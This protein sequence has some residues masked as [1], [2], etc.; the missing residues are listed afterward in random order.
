MSK[1]EILPGTPIAVIG[2]G[3]WYPGAQTLRELWEN[4][5]ARRRQFRRM[6]DHRLPL[7]DYHDPDPAVPDKTYGTRAAV[8]DGFQFDWMSRHVPKLTYETADIVHW[9]AL[10]VA[11]KALADAGFTRENVPNEKTGV[12]LGNSLTGEQTRA[13]TLR[14]RWPFVRRALR[15]AAEA[16]G[17]SSIVPELELTMEEYY[18]SVFA[19]TTEDSL[20]GGLSNTVAGRICNFLNFHGGGYTVDGACSSSLIAVA[21]AATA[22]ANRDMDLAL[23][24]GV[25]VSLDT[26]E[27]IGFAKTGA[28]TKND[29]TVYDRKASGFIPGEGCGFVILKRLEDAQRDGNYV[30]AV[31]RGWG[32]SSDG[33]GGLT[34]PSKE[35]Q[36]TAL[37]RA[38]A[39]AG[40]SPKENAFFEGHGTGT[41]VGD[42]TE[43]QGIALATGSDYDD[44]DLRV[45]GVTS[46]KSLVG[47]TKAASG[48]GGFIKAVMAVNRCV[49]PPTAGCK[50]PNPMFNDEAKYL[51]PVLQ[52]AVR[53]SRHVLRAGVS[54][55]GFG[56]INCHVALESGDAPAEQLTPVIDERALLVSNQDSEV[57]VW[58]AETLSELIEQ[59]EQTRKQ[60]DGISLAEVTDLAAKLGREATA[61]SVR[62]AFIAGTPDELLEQLDALLVLLRD[63]PPDVAGELVTNPQNTLWAGNAVQKNR[64]GFL[65]PG[66]GAQQVNM[67]RVLVERYAWARDMVTAADEALKAAGAEPVSPLIF[68]PLDRALND[69]QAK[70]WANVLSRTEVAQPAICLASMI[71]LQYLARLGIAP[72]VVGGHSLGELTAFYAVGAFDQN[73]LIRLAALRGCAMAAPVGEAGTMAS[74]MCAQDIAAELV[75]D[76]PEYVVVANINSPKQTVIS[77]SVAGVQAVVE[78]AKARDIQTVMLSVSNAFHSRFVA[79]AADILRRDAP[80]PENL[81]SLNNVLL[82]STNGQPVQPGSK[83]RDHFA[84]QILSQVDFIALTRA[85]AHTC[86]VMI[87]VGPGRALSGLV[88]DTLPSAICL[89]VSSKPGADRDLNT[90]LARLFVQGCNIHWDALYENRLIRPFVPVKE[91][92]FIENQC[93]RPF[94]VTQKFAP[95]PLSAGGVVEATLASSANVS[96]SILTE[97]LTRRGRFLAEV[98]RADLD[99]PPLALPR[100]TQTVQVVTPVADAVPVSEQSSAGSEPARRLPLTRLIELVAQRTGYPVESISP[101]ARLLDDLNLDSIKAGDLIATVAKEYGI[102]GKIEP[103]TLANAALE[104]IANAVTAQM[105]DVSITQT[106]QQPS[107]PSKPSVE[108]VLLA[109]VE[110]RTGFPRQSLDLRMRLLDDL[111]LDSIKAGDL[112]ART[113]KELGVSGQIEPAK[114][115]NASLEDIAD[116]LRLFTGAETAAPVPAIPDEDRSQTWVRDFV[117]EWVAEAI[118]ATAVDWQ[119]ASILVLHDADEARIARLLRGGLLSQGVANVQTMPVIEARDKNLIGSVTYTHIIVLLPASPA[120]GFDLR[121]AVER[122]QLSTA[123]LQGATLAIVQ[124]G[125]CENLE[126]HGAAA[127]AA[128][129]HLER[130]DLR[131]RVVNFSAQTESPLL[132]KPLLNELATAEAFA[133]IIYTPEFT[134]FLP[135]PLVQERSSYAPRSIT[136]SAEDVILVTGGAKGI[137]AECALALAK[138]TGVK[139]AL[140]GSS[141]LGAEV[142][143]TLGRFHD[144]GL[145]AHY[146]VC[147]VADSAAVKT[148]VQQVGH[149]LGAVTGVIHGAALNKPRRAEG[150]SVQDALEE[151]TPKVSGALNLCDALKDAPPKLFIGFSS[152]IGVTGMPGNAWYG[153]SNELLNLILQQFHTE[154][155]ETQVI[156]MAFSVWGEV[157]MGAR[158]GSTHA[159]ARMGIDA[160]PIVEGVEHFLKLALHNPGAEQVIVAA[161]LGG[162]DTWK[163]TQPKLPPA[164]RYLETVISSEPGVDVVAQAHLSFERD[165]YVKDHIYNDSSLFPTVFGLEAMGQAAAFVTG[166][167]SFKALRIEDVRLERPIVVDAD[168]GITI[169]IRALVQERETPDEAVRVMVGISTEQSGF[170]KDHFSAMF[171]LDEEMQSSVQTLQLPANALD[172]EP[173]NDLYTWLLFQGPLFQRIQGVYALDSQRCLFRTEARPYLEKNT[174]SDGAT[175]PFILGDPYFRDSLLQ[176]AQLNVSQELSLP[177]RIDRI[178]LFD[179]DATVTAVRDAAAIFESQDERQIV[180]SILATDENGRVV[181]RLEGYRL[182]ILEHHAEHPTPEQIADPALFDA[183]KLRGTLRQQ[184]DV[185]NILVPEITL[186]YLR[187][188]ELPREERHAAEQSILT[189]VVQR[190][191]NML[192]T[193]PRIEWQNGRKPTIKGSDFGL[194]LSHDDRACLCAAGQGAQGCDITHVMHAPR[195]SFVALLSKKRDGLLTQLTNAG[196]TLAYAGT[197]IWTAIEALYKAVNG[198]EIDLTLERQVGTSVL[199]RGGTSGQTLHVLTFPVMLT[200]GP[201]RMVAVV[202]QPEPTTSA[203]IEGFDSSVYAIDVGRSGPHG[204]L[205]MALRF[206]LSFRE[207]ATLS[208]NLY[209]SH[210]FA[211]MGKLREAACQPV[212]GPLSDQLATGKWGMVTNYAE[213]QI[214]K[215]VS[216]KDV[217]EGRV[218]IENQYGPANAALD[219]CFEWRRIV[220]GGQS[221]SVAVGKMAATWVAILDHGMVK[222]QPF[223]DYFQSYLNRMKPSAEPQNV[224]EVSG[225]TD[226]G[227]EIYRAAGGPSQQIVLREQCFETALEDTNLVG[228]IYFANYSVWQG[229]TIDHFLYEVAPAYF[230]GVGEQGEF[231][232]AYSRI[233]HLREAMPFDTIAVRM[234]L[235]A[236]YERGFRLLFEYYRVGDDGQYHKL[237]FGEHISAWYV[238]SAGEWQS[239]LLP[240]VFRDALLRPVMHELK[241]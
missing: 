216:A 199:F 211:W 207:T 173:S 135:R 214:V 182:Q 128:S 39:R 103:A 110:Q 48:I 54:A 44:V 64:V 208:R 190:L 177:I 58:S 113:A 21:T 98:I 117:I 18:K 87:E 31:L 202:V 137:T 22:L 20:S 231:R 158:M 74:L 130:P 151:V 104:T 93:E 55:M 168:K 153:F 27:L 181:E 149:E 95:I 63:N 225:K 145:T 46:F 222:A 2:M 212:Y 238:P 49:V 121:R 84:N 13:N 80:V 175:G 150:V 47:H 157:G 228:N 224:W 77:G 106:V 156:S 234:A 138:E 193:Q 140:V 114:Y 15:A 178:E 223:P 184:A 37:R 100:R 6:P 206:P 12:I 123:D 19:P 141:Q 125:G 78:R 101:L 169:Q 229:R 70:S 236:I 154:H 232:C 131:I 183:D 105:V 76:A 92:S 132:A 166:R 111:N 71:W 38:Y 124:F 186:A 61:Q 67:A 167:S 8:I 29:M 205:V 118:P 129:L 142:A 75:K 56:G 203:L 192:E 209:F 162:L 161:R 33:K 11:L 45:S 73:S 171:V 112:V 34:A 59:V 60:A 5:L 17:L 152:I 96:P 210:Y 83:L 176:S 159:L 215:T 86:D 108:S 66:Q 164:S 219:L 239:A 120:N 179:L 41:T 107:E 185:F 81:D 237:A 50:D 3:C 89:P 115:A 32:I 9:L 163:P 30:Y 146:F 16:R 35:G 170:E 94:N 147:N 40:Y 116:A 155:A 127:F 43:L 134:R 68:R 126:S 139:M 197:R 28:L 53:D 143:Q 23:A 160:I 174:A 241:G 99:M 88:R 226:L 188:H 79:A 109:L 196:D 62:A 7:V 97:Y 227:A 85:M 57:F 10:E 172:I 235:D 233:E 4:I 198:P 221:Q 148:L 91:R 194:S 42:K 102:A 26:F 69:D 230:H 240:Q 144:A 213:V 191:P 200:R 201:E 25:D 119:T 180:E 72:S 82:S 220:P 65:F 36:A 136:W 187:L 52:G 51:Y 14:Q 217:V 195:E 218:W 122:L 189:E 1:S 204:Q 90:V 133:H 24:G 165:A